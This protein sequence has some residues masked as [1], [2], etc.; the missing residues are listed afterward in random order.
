MFI[1]RIFYFLLLIQGITKFKPFFSIH[2][3]EE[4]IYLFFT[5]L[6]CLLF[7]FL[8]D[9]HSVVMDKFCLHLKNLFDK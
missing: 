3:F 8:T 4:N 5:L 9:L 2:L 6:K 7:K 1:E